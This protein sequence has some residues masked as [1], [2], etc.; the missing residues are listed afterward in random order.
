VPR[1][2][3]TPRSV[4]LAVGRTL[5]DPGLRR[6]AGELAAWAAAHDGAVRAADLVERAAVR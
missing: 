4:R 3:C 5:A 6:R 2:L 1:R